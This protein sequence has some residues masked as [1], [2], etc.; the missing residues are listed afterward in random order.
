[1]PLTVAYRYPSGTIPA[2]AISNT[3][4]GAPLG[5]HVAGAGAV[6]AEPPVPA[7]EI[8]VPPPQPP[9]APVVPC[10]PCDP[11]EPPAP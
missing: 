2:L 3:S 11:A 8:E 9:V 6:I 7:C 5:N 4:K 1:M 10:E